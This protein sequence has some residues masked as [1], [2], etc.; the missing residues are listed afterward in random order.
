MSVALRS[1]VV[2]R[3]SLDAAQREAM[4]A[5]MRLCYEG[6]S[7][8]RFASDLDRKDH[9]VL[10]TA[11]PHD[12]IVGFTTIQ[13]AEDTIDGRPVDL[14]YSGDTVLHPDW[15]GA[16]TLQMAFGRFVLARRLARP[17]RRCLWLLLSGGYKTYLIMVHHLPR[18]F[19]SRGYEPA[20]AERAFLARI[21]R[22][23]F[24]D[25]FDAARGVVRFAASHYRVRRSVV[26]LDPAT[27]ADPDVAFFLDRNPGHGDGDELV[28]LAE[29]RAIDLVRVLAR[30]A[31]RQIG[32]RPRR[33]PRPEQ[34]GVPS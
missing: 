13:L 28:C 3:A 30:M 2:P 6:V 14:V 34:V 17:T 9:V 5:L 16:K 22:D 25:Q 11:P 10:V 1:R 7:A 27:A 4:L 19:P 15:W 29:L 21:A 18:A 8:E 26:P 33:A 31:A 20:P 23:W 24:G 32:F 12:E